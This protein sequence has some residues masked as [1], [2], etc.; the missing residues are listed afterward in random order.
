M[1]VCHRKI[2]N[3]AAGPNLEATLRAKGTLADR[4]RFLWNCSLFLVTLFDTK[5]IRTRDV[6]VVG[7]KVAYVALDTEADRWLDVPGM[8]I[9][10]AEGAG[11]WPRHIWRTCQS[12]TER[13][14]RLGEAC[15]GVSGIFLDDRW[16]EWFCVFPTTRKQLNN[17]LRHVLGLD[18]GSDNQ[19]QS[20]LWIECMNLNAMIDGMGSGEISFDSLVFRAQCRCRLPDVLFA[21]ARSDVDLI[22]I[23]EPASHGHRVSRLESKVTKAI[24]T[25]PS[26]SPKSF[27]ARAVSSI[28]AESMP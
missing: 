28:V 19:S 8:R 5:R 10:K 4:W 9:E 21:I 24:L 23:G 7:N 17:V 25:L 18:A 2:N 12:A 6:V 26:C 20:S 15:C 1:Q 13:H 14:C 3:H 11:F 16:L 27:F 22:E